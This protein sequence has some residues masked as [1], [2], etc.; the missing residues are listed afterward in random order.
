MSNYCGGITRQWD[1]NGG[2]CGVCGDPW[3]QDPRDHEPGGNFLIVS[4]VLHN[5]CYNILAVNFF[6]NK[7]GEYATGIIGKTYYEGEEINITIDITANHYGY[8]EFRLCKNDEYMKKVEQNCFDEN[9]LLIY[10]NN[11][12]VI[13]H[14]KIKVISRF[15]MKFKLRG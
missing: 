3:D 12:D 5:Y 7:K 11:E 2:K 9:L 13:P 8:F 14:N 1:T 10:N 4:F 15:K 6:S